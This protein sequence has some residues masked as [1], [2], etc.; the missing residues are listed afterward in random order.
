[1]LEDK[2][3]RL[4]LTK[5]LRATNSRRSRQA[6]E[7]TAI[8]SSSNVEFHTLFMVPLLWS[9]SD[10]AMNH[11]ALLALWID[12]YHRTNW[13]PACINVYKKEVGAI[14]FLLKFIR[15]AKATRYQ[16]LSRV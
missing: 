4:S 5:S 6:A 2:I 11:A 7:L 12:D 16:P 13:P 8:K 9:V 3:P 14:C 15:A 1:S 10:Y